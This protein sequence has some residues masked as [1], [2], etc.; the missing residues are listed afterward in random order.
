MD[1]FQEMLAAAAAEYGLTLS[2]AQLAAMD[3][4]YRL[5]VE[6]N[7]KMN[8]TAITQP[9]EVAVKHMV[10]SLSC[11]EPDI[12]SPG[13]SLIDVGTGA[14]FPG[15]PL[16]IYQQDI[17]LTLMDSLNKRLNFLQEVIGQLGLTG[18][19]T[20]HA[21]AEEGGRQKQHREVYQL[22]VSR[23]VARLNVLCELCLP[24]VKPGGWFVALKGAQYEEEVSQAAAAITK[25]GGKVENIKPVALPGLTD[26]RAVIYIK[27]VAVTPASYPRKA[28]TP[29]KKPL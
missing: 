25:L 2:G 26:K 15:L 19:T 9:E 22:A 12:F 21:R 17:A 7:Q 20:V 27:K 3:T 4:Y 8:L 6:W 29:E 10:D 14:G 28:G 18:V 23:A 11:Y 1:N 24:F 5:L 13:V 16:K